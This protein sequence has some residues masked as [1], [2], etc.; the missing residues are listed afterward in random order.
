MARREPRRRAGAG[1]AAGVESSS[2]GPGAAGQ[3]RPADGAA[4]VERWNEELRALGYR[5]PQQVGLPIVASAPRAGAV[6][7]E[8]AVGV[9]LSR[10]GARRSAWNAADIRG[11]VEQWIAATGLVAD[12]AIRI[13][14]AEDLTARALEACGPLLQRG[15]VPEHIRALTSPE[16]LAVEADIVPGSSTA[17]SSPPTSPASPTLNGAG[18]ASLTSRS[19]ETP[20]FWSSKARQGPARPPPSRLPGRCLPSVGIGWSW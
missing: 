6:D 2:V 18:Q 15:D 16:V 14:L 12:A 20:H 1:A 8:Q 9:V 19:A 4:L 5:D 10:L 13:D 17:Q 11:E 7:R 3:G